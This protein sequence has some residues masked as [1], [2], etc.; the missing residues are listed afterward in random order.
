MLDFQLKLLFGDTVVKLGKSVSTWFLLRFLTRLKTSHSEITP[1]PTMSL[2]YPRLLPLIALPLSN[3]ILPFILSTRRL[4][5][6]HFSACYTCIVLFRDLLF[7]VCVCAH[8]HMSSSTHRGQ[9]KVSDPLA[10]EL[11]AC[12]KPIWG[13]ASKVGFSVRAVRALSHRAISPAPIYPLLLS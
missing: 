1:P 8:T 10:L 5:Y 12:K 4:A 7:Y 9:K 6:C 2:P 13:L 11:Q 3:Y